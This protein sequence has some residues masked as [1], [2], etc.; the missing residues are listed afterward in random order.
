MKNPKLA[1]TW[2]LCLEQTKTT[3]EGAKAAKASAARDAWEEEG[4][5]EVGSGDDGSEDQIVEEA[6]I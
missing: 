6:W 1:N 3:A 2:T 4:R 5:S